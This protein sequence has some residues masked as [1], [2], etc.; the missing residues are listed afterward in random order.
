MINGLASPEGKPL[1][2]SQSKISPYLGM[3]PIYCP[4]SIHLASVFALSKKGAI[5]PLWSVDA[6]PCGF[7]KWIG[8]SSDIRLPAYP[9]KDTEYRKRRQNHV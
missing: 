3:L 9:R 4:I 1:G 8:S 5:Q 6:T 2:L 7:V